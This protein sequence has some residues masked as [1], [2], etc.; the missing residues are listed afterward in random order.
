MRRP[1]RCTAATHRGVAW[2]SGVLCMPFSLMPSPSFLGETLRSEKLFSF[3]CSVDW[4]ILYLFVL[5]LIKIRMIF[6]KTCI[7]L[8][9]Y[10][11]FWSWCCAS[12]LFSVYLVKR[13]AYFH[14]FHHSVHF[15]IYQWIFILLCIVC[16]FFSKNKN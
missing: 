15:N 8:L 6:I 12:I 10:F 5:F 14:L 2:S 4:K 13:V 9:Y 16:L 1:G 7:C 3:L 11:L